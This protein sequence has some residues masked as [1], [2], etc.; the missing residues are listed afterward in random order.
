MGDEL[1]N[2]AAVSTPIIGVTNKDFVS[3]GLGYFDD[4]LE[5][6]VG[7]TSTLKTPSRAVVDPLN[8][9]SVAFAAQIG[10]KFGYKKGE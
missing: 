2:D 8:D 9:S 10:W 4:R 3:L 7:V 5:I 6:D 1:A